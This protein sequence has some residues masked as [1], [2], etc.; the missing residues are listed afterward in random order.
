MAGGEE[1]GDRLIV[2]IRWHYRSTSRHLPSECPEPTEHV[3]RLPDANL[4]RR[5]ASTPSCPANENDTLWVGRAANTS[6]RDGHSHATGLLIRHLL[7]MP[8]DPPPVSRRSRIAR[9]LA[10]RRAAQQK[11]E[12]RLSFVI[13]SSTTP[14]AE[15]SPHWQDRATPTTDPRCVRD[16]TSCL[17]HDAR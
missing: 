5:F 1:S 10:D 15:R 16:R 17:Q 13:S 2:R 3:A 7:A 8:A 6:V 14:R 11:Q 4:P 12:V 9:L